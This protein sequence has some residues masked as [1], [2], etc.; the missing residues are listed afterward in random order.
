MQSFPR[1]VRPSLLRSDPIQPTHLPPPCRL[2]LYWRRAVFK[3]H[4]R[5]HARRQNL[6]L[7]ACLLQGATTK[8]CVLDQFLTFRRTRSQDLQDLGILD[9][10]H[11]LKIGLYGS[12][13]ATGK[14]H[15]TPEAI[16]MGLE[17]SDPE[18]IE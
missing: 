9:K 17:G 14:G 1:L 15:M 8:T 7:G 13:A 4:C 12:L 10:V 11:K 5:S 18:T 2:V 16:M 3:P 6:C